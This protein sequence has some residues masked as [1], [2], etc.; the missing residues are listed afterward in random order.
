MLTAKVGDSIINCFDGTYDRYRLKQWSNKGILKCPVCDGDY[1]YCHGE[2]ISPYFRHIG[3]E[4]NGYYSETETDEHRNGKLLIYNWI[5]DQKG[6]LNCK[7]ESWVPETKQRP[8]IYFEYN[9]KKFVIEYQCTPIASEFLIRRELYKL[10]GITDIWILGVEKYRINIDKNGDPCHENK[11]KIIEQELK[12]N[13]YLFYFDSKNKIFISDSKILLNQG[14][15]QTLKTLPYFFKVNNF[16]LFDSYRLNGDFIFIENIQNFI[17]DNYAIKLNNYIIDMLKTIESHIVRES[18]RIVKELDSI[19]E[20]INDAKIKSS[21][22]GNIGDE[23]ELEVMLLEKK[24]FTSV[25]NK[26]TK[27]ITF[28]DKHGNYLTWF[29]TT[30]PYL[31]KSEFIKLKGKIKAHSNYDGIKQTVLTRCLI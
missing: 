20:K 4:C 12:I 21:H 22:I 31:L 24:T 30:N 11:Y 5:K 2:V 16:K 10:A 28:V 26:S 15:L 19:R 8:D 27:C 6:V 25:F 17:F 7:L 3:K 13:D 23:I 9:G 1:E 14:L 29:T 18:L